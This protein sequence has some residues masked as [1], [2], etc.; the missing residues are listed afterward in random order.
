MFGTGYSSLPTMT[1]CDW[2]EQ[3]SKEEHSHDLGIMLNAPVDMGSDLL[4]RQEVIKTDDEDD[5]DDTSQL[6][7]RSW[8][9]WKNMHP[10]GYGNRQNM[11]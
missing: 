11:G 10:K 3:H 4:Q 5:D 8:V 7:A 2:Y 6:R 1:V 9:D